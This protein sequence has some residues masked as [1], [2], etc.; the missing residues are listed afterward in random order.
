MTIQDV[1]TKYEL[2]KKDVSDV[3]P[4]LFI[5]WCDQIDRYIKNQ[6]IKTDPERFI[7]TQSYSVT[8]EY[9]T[10]ALPADF[11]FLQVRGTGFFEVDSST[12]RDLE[13]RLSMIVHGQ[14]EE[15]YRIEGNNIV[16]NNCKDKTYTL[17]YIPKPTELTSLG[18]TLVVPD[19]YMDFMIYAVDV[20]YNQWDEMEGAE[21]LADFRNGRAM[22]DLLSQIRRDDYVYLQP[23]YTQDY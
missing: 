20:Y 2:I 16:F 7:S 3:A 8:S 10:A 14:K 1:L 19:E 23:D 5:Y 6:I 15:G 17:R 21:S 18:S 4:D 9:E 13:K 22:G 11:K 12:G